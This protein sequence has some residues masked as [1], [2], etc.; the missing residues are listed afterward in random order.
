PADPVNPDAPFVQDVMITFPPPDDPDGRSTLLVATRPGAPARRPEVASVAAAARAL[1]PPAC[2]LLTIE[3]PGTLDGGDVLLYGDRVVIGLSG[4][5]NRAGAEQLA[6]ALGEIGYRVFLCP[7]TDARLHFAS[8]ITRVRATRFI[9]T[10]VGFA[11]LDAV[12]DDVLPR[13]EIDRVVIPDD[14]APA[15]N[16]VLIG[17]TLFVPAG[18]PVSVGMLRDA[19]EHVAEV[20]FEQFTFAD[21]GLTC[22]M[23]V[24]Y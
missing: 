13:G 7:V 3:K 4:R 5:T 17:D 22:L 24:V 21:A 12:G 10:A 19:G 11:D 16:V 2:R 20:R 6:R 8:A 15:H 9:G 18:N 14:E 1:V 23:G